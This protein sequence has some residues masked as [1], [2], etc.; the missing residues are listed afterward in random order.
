[1][2]D[3]LPYPTAQLYPDVKDFASAK[4]AWNK[5]NRGALGWLQAKVSPVIWQDF[6]SYNRASI[7]WMELENHCRKAEGIMTDLQLV[8]M[9][10]IQFTNST[11]LLPQIQEFHEN[12]AQIMLN[13]HSKLSEDL[14]TFMLCSSLPKSYE[15]TAWQYLNN[16]T[17][18]ENYEVQDIIA[19]VLQEESRRK[20]QAVGSGLSLN[21]FSAVKN[22][23]QKC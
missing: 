15:A 5:N 14:A 12:Y 21:K 8:N 2:Y 10:K 11:D 4:A 23:G 22:L 19:Q 1:M 17:N 13:R 7:L 6:I 18:I 20:A 9:V 3:L 16:I